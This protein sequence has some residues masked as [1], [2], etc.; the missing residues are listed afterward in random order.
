MG[1]YREVKW[2]NVG[3]TRDAEANFNIYNCKKLLFKKH[4]H[5]KF[6]ILV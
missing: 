4:G 2:M 1:V 6:T 3:R 5:C